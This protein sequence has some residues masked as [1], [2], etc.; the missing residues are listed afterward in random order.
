MV[1]NDASNDV[2]D[3]VDPNDDASDYVQAMMQ[4]MGDV[5]VHDS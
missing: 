1:N 3:Y 4:V 2:S 5:G